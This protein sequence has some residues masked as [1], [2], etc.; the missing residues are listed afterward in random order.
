MI[1]KIGQNNGTTVDHMIMKECQNND[2]YG[3]KEREKKRK[4]MIAS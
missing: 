1:D 3:K 2:S 4:V